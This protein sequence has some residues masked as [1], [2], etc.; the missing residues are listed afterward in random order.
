MGCL[1]AHPELSVDN[2]FGASQYLLGRAFKGRPDLCHI[3]NMIDSFFQVCRSESATNTKRFW[4]KKITTEQSQG[5]NK[6]N[7]FHSDNYI[8]PVDHFFNVRCKG[9]KV[10][11]IVRN[12]KNCIK[13]KMTRTDA[14]AEVSAK[15]WI[16]GVDVYRQL[17]ETKRELHQVKYENLVN[18]PEETL[19]QVCQFIGVPYSG[20]MLAGTNNPKIIPAYRREGFD[21]AAANGEVL[22][23]PEI[24]SLIEKD[25]AYLGY[26][27]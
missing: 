24:I 15:L 8:D 7:R 1:D 3:D 14:G 5:L 21:V 2:E 27:I 26:S 19:M 13:S 18:S 23:D 22:L 9:V 25:M 6:H 17:R 11:F 10:I 20:D 4:G 16:Y 12:G